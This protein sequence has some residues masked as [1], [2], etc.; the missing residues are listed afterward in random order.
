MRRISLVLVLCMSLAGVV[1]AGCGGSTETAA[2]T[3]PP[4]ETPVGEEGAEAGA[5]VEVE[6]RDTAFDPEEVS[7]EAGDT[8]AWENYDDFDHNAVATSGADFASDNFGKGG[9]YEWVAAKPGVVEYECT[10]HP[11][12]TGRIDVKK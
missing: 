1:L 11:G 3:A 8:V 12:M 6:M 4:S 7:V 10:L 2:D 9:T 5:T